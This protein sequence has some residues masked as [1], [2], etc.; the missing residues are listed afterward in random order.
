MHCS[1]IES[2]MLAKR[3]PLV[4]EAAFPNFQRV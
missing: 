2:R 1:C 3:H 4:D